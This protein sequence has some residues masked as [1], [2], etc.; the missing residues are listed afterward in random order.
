M[1]LTVY[2]TSTSG[3]AFESTIASTT[4]PANASLTIRLTGTP[5]EAGKLII[6]G[7]NIKIAGFS[8][9]EFLM[10][11]T[12]DNKDENTKTVATQ[13]TKATG[14]SSSDTIGSEGI[15]KANHL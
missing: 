6:K 1:Q 7:C 9:Q 4:I 11:A 10:E 15:Y 14:Q 8:E 3:A 5:K 13:G 12:V 2:V